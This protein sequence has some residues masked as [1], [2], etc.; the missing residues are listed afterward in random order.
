[1]EHLRR[2]AQEAAEVLLKNGR[3]LP[4]PALEGRERL[5]S[6]GNKTLQEEDNEIA[7]TFMA[8]AA[9][10]S[11]PKKA[12]ELKWARLRQLQLRLRRQFLCLN[13]QL[14]VSHRLHLRS[15]QVVRPLRR[16]ARAS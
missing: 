9:A 2:Q 8:E 1:M 7:L 3:E 15:G 11:E 12:V 10:A 13:Q 5:K 4:N 16:A 6:T 14:H